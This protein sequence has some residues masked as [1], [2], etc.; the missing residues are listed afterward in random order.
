[1]NFFYYTYALTLLK[2]NLQQVSSL[3]FDTVQFLSFVQFLVFLSLLSHTPPL[4]KPHLP[5]RYLGILL[6]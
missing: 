2:V 6:Y 4:N 3:M 1:M 5:P